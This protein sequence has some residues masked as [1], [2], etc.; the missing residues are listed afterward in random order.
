MAFDPTTF[1]P[2]A[3]VSIGA[4]GGVPSPEPEPAPL[5]GPPPSDPPK[6]AIALDEEDAAELVTLWTQNV[7]Q[8][9]TDAYELYTAVLRSRLLMSGKDDSTLYPQPKGWENPSLDV[10]NFTGRAKTTLMSNVLPQLLPD[11]LTFT[12][13]I[14][15]KIPN[16]RGTK[17][18]QTLLERFYQQLLDDESVEFRESIERALDHTYTDG[19][20]FGM[21][22]WR[23]EKRMRTSWTYSRED[24]LDA[25][26]LQPISSTEDWKAKRE[27]QTVTDVP[28]VIPMPCCDGDGKAVVGT[29]PATHGDLQRSSAVFCRW[30]MTGD[31]CQQAVEA[32][33]FDKHAVELLKQKVVDEGRQSGDDKTRSVATSMPPDHFFASQR[34]VITEY[35]TLYV[36]PGKR[37]AEEWRFFFS[38]GWLIMLH[39]NPSAWF[40]GLR[41]IFHLRA[42]PD[43]T[44]I[45]ADSLGDRAGEIQIAMTT[46]LRLI[47]NRGRLMVNPEIGVPRGTPQDDLDVLTRKRGEG[48]LLELYEETFKNLTP[49]DAGANP[50][51][52][53]QLYDKLKQDGEEATGVSNT[54][55][56]ALERGQPTN[57]QR[58]LAS[59]ESSTAINDQVMRL[60][61]GL[62][63]FGAILKGMV[64]QFQGREN[65]QR[66][67]RK[68]NPDA[69]PDDMRDALSL[70]HTLFPAC[71]TLP[72]SLAVRQQQDMAVFQA[73]TQDPLIMRN[74]KTRYY[75]M[76]KHYAALGESQPENILGTEEEYT[77]AMM[78]DQKQAELEMLRKQAEAELQAQSKGMAQ[79]GPGGVAAGQPP[80]GEVGPPMP[81]GGMPEQSQIPPN[82]LQAMQAGGMA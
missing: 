81:E 26:T 77:A 8:S 28:V 55:F 16:G 46:I 21:V 44:G 78:A 9:E 79:G 48:A 38:E 80:Q 58:E 24:K 6:R 36:P 25:M 27:L 61:S 42:F 37:I 68:A 59:M 19:V 5:P 71:R 74:P 41:N 40:S 18:Y 17:Y 64:Y 7:M 12:V 56:S 22:P 62:L 65:M 72:G 82:V 3:M 31:E 52:L 53:L 30:E 39:A 51:F 45:F 15:G 1:D 60:S 75:V 10:V 33:L 54:R 23:E 69:G 70:P 20:C 13:E 11:P 57:L 47:I 63:R 49:I 67:F 29:F 34:F 76:S 35:Q 73:A 43:K 2:S 66:I 4:A 32:G 14:E 50:V